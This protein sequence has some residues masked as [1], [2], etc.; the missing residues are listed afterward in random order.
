MRQRNALM[1]I[2][3]KDFGL[4]QQQ[5]ADKLEEKGL[6]MDRSMVGKAINSDF[7]GTSP[8]NGNGNGEIILS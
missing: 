7:E 2:L 6:G 1:D 4:T 3:Y 5:I 8:E